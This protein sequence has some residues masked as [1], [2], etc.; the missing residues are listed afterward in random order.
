[1][2]IRVN[3]TSRAKKSRIKAKPTAQ[4]HPT[5]LKGWCKS[6]DFLGQPTSVAQ[7]WVRRECLSLVKGGSVSD[8]SQQA[9]NPTQV[10]VVVQFEIHRGGNRA[11]PV[12]KLSA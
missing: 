5:S 2:R 9:R 6:Q 8:T 7:R 11:R 10:P 3:R 1:M 4:P 12:G